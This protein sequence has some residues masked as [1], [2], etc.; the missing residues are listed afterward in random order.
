MNGMLNWNRE[1]VRN[2]TAVEIWLFILGRVLAAFAI[3]II[4]E[5]YFPF[6]ARP[7]A[8]PVLAVG[9][10]LFAIAAKGLFRKTP[11]QS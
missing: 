7:I 10:I 5:E 8:F 4:V 9:L 1:K 11:T 6:I 3:G 2:L